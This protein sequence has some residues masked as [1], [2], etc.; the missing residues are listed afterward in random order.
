MV[1]HSFESLAKSLFQLFKSAIWMVL[2]KIFTPFRD[3]ISER[4]T[5][6][7]DDVSFHYF[8]ISFNGFFEHFDVSIKINVS[9]IGWI[10]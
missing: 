7:V 3:T 10:L 2:Y 9:N 6:H 8:T 1:L 4:K 5:K